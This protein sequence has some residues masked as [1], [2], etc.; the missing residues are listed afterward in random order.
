MLT[1]ATHFSLSVTMQNFKREESKI[2]SKGKRSKKLMVVRNLPPSY[3][4]IPGEDYNVKESEVIK[5]LIQRPS[6]LE[7]LW[8]QCKQ[9]K[10]IVY[11]PRTGKWQGVDYKEDEV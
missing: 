6:I 3:H 7:Y 1:P 10:D 11:S 8:D 2:M 4:R 9:S 5:W